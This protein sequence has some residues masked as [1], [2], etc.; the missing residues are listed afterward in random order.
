MHDG[1]VTV[2]FILLVCEITYSERYKWNF[3]FGVWKVMQISNISQNI[4]N[5]F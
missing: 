1:E 2:E 4:L 3:N 5:S